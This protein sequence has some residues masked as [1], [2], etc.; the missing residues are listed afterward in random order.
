MATPFIAEIRMFG[1]NFPPR[2]WATCDGQ[3]LAI[4]QNQALFSLLGT[5][6]GGNGVTTFALPNLKGRLPYHWGQGIGLSS[7]T[8]GQSGGEENHTLT[9]S[10]IPTHNHQI[11]ASNA[12]SNVGAATNDFFAQNKGSYSSTANTT[13][14]ANAIASAG[15]NQPHNNMAP[16]LVVNFSIAL[17]GVFPSRS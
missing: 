5:T 11:P 17:T 14:A 9:L 13:M 6:F 8:L 10:E 7:Y 3:L 4:A 2:G 12:D 15:G 1:F 16:Y